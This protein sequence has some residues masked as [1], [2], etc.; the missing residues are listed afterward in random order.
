MNKDFLYQQIR[1]VEMYSSYLII[2]GVK[3]KSISVVRTILKLGNKYNNEGFPVRGNYSRFVK[4][5]NQLIILLFTNRNGMFFKEYCLRPATN[6]DI[7]AVKKI[8]F[9]SLVEYGLRPDPAVRTGTWMTSRKIIFPA[10]DFS[11]CR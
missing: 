3:T 2:F 1:I 8:V 10:M 6:D 4:S 9:S 7:P 11:G 5:N